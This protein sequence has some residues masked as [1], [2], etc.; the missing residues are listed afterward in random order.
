MKRLL[1]IF[2][3]VFAASGVYAQK[4][5]IGTNAPTE[6]LHISNGNLRLDG[7]FM[8]NNLAGN[9]GQ[10]LQSAG[11]GVAPVWVDAPS[12]S[13]A[14]KNKFVAR[15][16]P[17]DNNLSY[18]LLQDDSIQV[19]I[20]STPTLPFY[21]HSYL[22]ST[23]ATQTKT[24]VTA[25]DTTLQRAGIYGFSYDSV[26]VYGLTYGNNGLGAAVRGQSNSTNT[27]VS[28]V[29]GVAGVNAGTNIAWGVHGITN[30]N[31]DY[32]GINSIAGSGVLGVG[33]VN[34]GNN[35]GVQ[36]L[37]LSAMEGTSGVYGTVFLT[38]NPGALDILPGVLGETSIPTFGVMGFNS[39][40]GL[41]DNKI[42]GV[43]VGTSGRT[44]AGG[45]GIG[46]EGI[47]FKF[48]GATTEPNAGPTYGVWGETQNTENGAAGV[49][50]IAYEKIDNGAPVGGGMN[51]GV[52][53]ESYSA[54]DSASGVYGHNDNPN[55]FGV[56]GTSA[57][58]TGV[59]GYHNGLTG[60]D[61]GVSAATSST[62]NGA[63]ALLAAAVGTG[64]EPTYAVYATSI[65]EADDAT[66]VYGLVEATTANATIGVFGETMSTGTG[67]GVLG[68]AGSTTGGQTS[69]VVGESHSPTAGATGV[70]G[71]NKST[72]GATGVFGVN[73]KVSFGEATSAGVRGDNE[74]G[75][76]AGVS[77]AG[78]FQ[79]NLNCTG[80]LTKG[81][82][83]FKIDHPLDP[84]NKYLYHTCPESPEA[85]NIYSGNITTNANGEAVVKLPAYFEAIN[86]NP[87]YQLTCVNQ[88][89]NAIVSQKIAD[90]QFVIKTDKPN[91]EVSWVIYGERNDKFH[92]K[93]NNP[94]EQEKEPQNKGKYLHP[95]AYDKPASMGIGYIP[96]EKNSPL[97]RNPQV[98]YKSVADKK[99]QHKVNPQAEEWR[100]MRFQKNQKFLEDY[101]KRTAQKAAVSPEK[102]KQ[103][104]SVPAQ[105]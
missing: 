72:A 23:V 94:I 101:Q 11:A 9:A 45:L 96:R 41:S 37:S 34:G 43:G 92:Q 63:A 22:F 18:G 65:A 73:G 25:T 20:R 30:N 14:G 13:V 46:V 87:R 58:G 67:I 16:S 71:V 51:A 33:G 100:K 19:A 39:N 50:G 105:N 80:I 61:P 35:H 2:L 15:Y 27:G 66:G 36:G 44:F 49:Y 17:T 6:R 86:I 47:S 8:P 98:V 31:S 57:G 91:V 83:Q 81:T 76:N 52:R 32:L 42:V 89:A 26:A 90:N 21:K 55:T 60:T 85:L 104:L 4:V 40:A 102:I 84:A 69:G 97:V 10:F 1:Y 54:A 103:I 12:G 38:A 95:L 62:D 59:L 28:G 99:I 74:T 77:F 53:G 24:G 5:G 93:F 48:P 79:G 29:Q 78:W 70:V 88:F 64:T 75:D 7:A 3:L 68:R 56:R 82:D